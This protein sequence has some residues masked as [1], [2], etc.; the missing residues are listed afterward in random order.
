MPLSPRYDP[1]LI[2]SPHAIGNYHIVNQII[3]RGLHNSDEEIKAYT[4]NLVDKLEQVSRTGSP[5]PTPAS[6][7]ASAAL[8]AWSLI[9]LSRN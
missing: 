7:L 6:P 1:P 8:R 4:I 9:T 3:E 2:R 5:I